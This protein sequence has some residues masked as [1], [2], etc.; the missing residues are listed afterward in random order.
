MSPPQKG[1]MMSNDFHLPT[2]SGRE[3]GTK[4][5]KI[6]EENGMEVERKRWAELFH[7]LSHPFPTLMIDRVEEMERDKRIRSLKWV[8]ANEFY[9]AGHFPGEP[10]L[11]GVLTLE[12][13]VQSALLLVTASFP[14]GRLRCTLEKVDRVRF[15]RA[16]IPGD[17]VDFTVQLLSKEDESW[18]FKGQAQV[19]GETAAEA[20]LA[21]KVLFREVGFDL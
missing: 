3:K 4:G 15:K 2:D 6:I 20:N 1:A 16:I 21:L 10:I 12:G 7:F 14:R 5:E 19:E 17:R 13:L 9:L 8:T 18:K 11:P